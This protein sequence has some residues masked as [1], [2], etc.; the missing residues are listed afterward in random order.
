MPTDPNTREF[1]QTAEL[2]EIL[3]QFREVPIIP[4]YTTGELLPSDP[5]DAY[6]VIFTDLGTDLER[7]IV[8]GTIEVIDGTDYIRFEVDTSLPGWTARA[9]FWRVVG[10]WTRNGT[11]RRFT[12]LRGISQLVHSS[13]QGSDALAHASSMVLAIRSVIKCRLNDSGDLLEYQIGGRSVRMMSLSELHHALRMYENDVV[14]VKGGWPYF[15][16][17]TLVI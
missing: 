12:F 9:W 2:G 13:E 14:R 7:P 16:T 8:D 6:W 3:I 4:Q 15:D 5:P 17:G 11:R 10:N 1:P